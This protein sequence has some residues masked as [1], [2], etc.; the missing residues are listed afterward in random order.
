MVGSLSAPMGHTAHPGS[1]IKASLG[2]RVA[3]R[4]RTPGCSFTAVTRQSSS[5]QGN[6]LRPVRRWPVSSGSRSTTQ[7]VCTST[8]P[9]PNDSAPRR[10]TY[11][12]YDEGKEYFTEITSP[13]QFDELMAETAAKNPDKLIIL[14]FYTRCVGCSRCSAATWPPLSPYP[15][16]P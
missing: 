2:E 15:P 1:L 7:T 9:K 6:A 10:T 12:W 14:E 16:A 5:F 11:N 3:T 4:A 13:K 8:V